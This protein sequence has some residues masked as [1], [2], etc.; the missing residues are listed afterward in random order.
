MD[1]MKLTKKKEKILS[2]KNFIETEAEEDDDLDNKDKKRINIEPL[3]DT[4]YSSELNN[5]EDVVNLVKD[6]RNDMAKEVK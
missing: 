1:K 3:K 2:I 6:V 5:E 4:Q